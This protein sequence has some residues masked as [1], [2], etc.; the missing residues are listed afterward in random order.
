MTVG[1]GGSIPGYPRVLADAMIALY[2]ISY[3]AQLH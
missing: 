2:F 3:D 1:R